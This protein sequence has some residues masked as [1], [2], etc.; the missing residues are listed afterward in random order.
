MINLYA[1]NGFLPKDKFKMERP[2]TARSPLLRGDYMVKRDLNYA[3][4]AVPIHPEST[5]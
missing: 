2:H 1:L 3:F 4:Y 5:K